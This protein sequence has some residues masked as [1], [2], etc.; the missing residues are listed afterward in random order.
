MPICFLPAGNSRSLTRGILPSLILKMFS[1][2]DFLQDMDVLFGAITPENRRRDRLVV[3]TNLMGRVYNEPEGS[4]SQLDTQLTDK[5]RSSIHSMPHVLSRI[6]NLKTLEDNSSL[7]SISMFPSRTDE[8]GFERNRVWTI[9]E[10]N[11][12]MKW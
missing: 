5:D 6:S 1:N 12:T 7:T 9:P 3:H 11:I 2:L 4:L 8:S 10:E